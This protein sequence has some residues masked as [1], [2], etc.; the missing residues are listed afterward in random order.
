MRS[1]KPLHPKRVLPPKT[2]ASTQTGGPE[3]PPVAGNQEGDFAY[4]VPV[5]G[6]APELVVVQVRVTVAPFLVMVN[7]LPDAELP[8]IV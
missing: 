8:T 3:G 7:L 4:Q 2:G 1:T 6:Q 5:L